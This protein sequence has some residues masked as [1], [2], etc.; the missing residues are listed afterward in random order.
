MF[1]AAFA[2]VIVSRTP[3]SAN[4]IAFPPYAG[5]STFVLMSG[6]VDVTV[7][8]PP[9][10]QKRRPDKPGDAGQLDEGEASASLR[11]MKAAER[12][13]EVPSVQCRYGRNPEQISGSG[14]T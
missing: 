5:S 14:S 7:Y 4:D 6:T 2:T 3:R 8:I 12:Q 1:H 13:Q 9:H 10:V 11:D